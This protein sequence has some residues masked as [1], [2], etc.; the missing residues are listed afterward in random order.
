[1]HLHRL[2]KCCDPFRRVVEGKIKVRTF[3]RVFSSAI[4]HLFVCVEPKAIHV[5]PRDSSMSAGTSGT[6]LDLIH[7]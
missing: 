3:E 1:M 5:S 2:R 7:R 6:A 4:F